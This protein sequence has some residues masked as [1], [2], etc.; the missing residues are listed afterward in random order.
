MRFKSYAVAWKSYDDAYFS[1]CWPPEEVDGAPIAEYISSVIV[2]ARRRSFVRR[3]VLDADALQMSSRPRAAP[4][5]KSGP[6]IETTPGYQDLF[7]VV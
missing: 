2:P 7:T 1:N 4:K 6:V 5:R 3:I